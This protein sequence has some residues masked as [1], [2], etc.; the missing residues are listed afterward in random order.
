MAVT[1]SVPARHDL[2]APD[3]RRDGST[4]RASCSSRACARGCRS[5]TTTRKRSAPTGSRTPSAPTTSTEVRASWSTSGTATTF[6]AISVDGEYLGGAIAPGLAHIARRPVPPR[7]GAPDASSWSSPEASSASRR[8]SRSSPARSTGS[9]HRSTGCAP[10][11]QREL[12]PCAVVAT[13][14]L[15]EIIAPLSKSIEHHEPW[16]TLHGLRLVYERNVR[17]S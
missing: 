11:S 6:D 8:S 16:L 10:G 17:H 3:G 7:C 14:G 5:S 12:G 1:S 13:G 15:C 9:P 2:A 4:S